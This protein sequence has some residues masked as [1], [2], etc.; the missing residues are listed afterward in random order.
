MGLV[1][2]DN[3]KAQ[4]TL[5]YWQS[6]LA[7]KNVGKW[8]EGLTW[9]ELCSR[10]REVCLDQGLV[11]LKADALLDDTV[12]DVRRRF[13]EHPGVVFPFNSRLTASAATTAIVGQEAIA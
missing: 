11:G 3:I 10:L 7:W 1:S 8:A 4:R 6:S 13:N 9:E 12:H 2:D 5:K